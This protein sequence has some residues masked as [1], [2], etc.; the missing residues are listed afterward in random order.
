MNFFVDFFRLFWR[1]FRTVLV[2]FW[3]GPGVDFGR[4][5]GRFLS[6][7]GSTLG[8]QGSILDH[9]GDDFGQ[10]FFGLFF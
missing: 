7:F 9:L 1:L 6:I 10:L 4:S 5:G 8:G 3:V 2:D